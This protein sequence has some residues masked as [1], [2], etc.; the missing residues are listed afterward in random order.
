[1]N[2]YRGYRSQIPTAA[3]VDNLAKLEDNAAKRLAAKALGL[4]ADAGTAAT[5]D[6]MDFRVWIAGVVLDEA[7]TEDQPSPYIMDDGEVLP[8]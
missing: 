4:S 2:N 7:E 1:M 6:A 5:R 3:L 8:Y